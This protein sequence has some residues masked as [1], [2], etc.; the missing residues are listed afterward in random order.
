MVVYD[1]QRKAFVVETIAG[2]VAPPE[3]KVVLGSNSF[4]PID[5]IMHS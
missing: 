3:Q 2:A 4:I 1:D 5:Q